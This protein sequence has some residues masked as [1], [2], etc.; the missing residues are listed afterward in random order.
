MY[1]DISN[2]YVKKCCDFA[3]AQLE[4]SSAVYARRGEP[5]LEKMRLDI[6]TGKMGEVAAYKYLKD[7]GINC[8]KP[9]FEIYEARRKSF[10]PDIVTDCGLNIH[11]KAQSHES[12]MRY[13]ASWL[14]Q[15]TDKLVK[16]PLPNDLILMVSIEGSQAKILGIVSAEEVKAN[17][18]FDQPRIPRYAVSKVALYFDGLKES[19]IDME[20]L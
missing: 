12:M 4:T 20:V 14:M 9:D 18:L 5:R 13:G 16:N 2:Y 17:N 19:D 7:K 11:V 3:D 6:I 1:V 8:S 15:K 10:D